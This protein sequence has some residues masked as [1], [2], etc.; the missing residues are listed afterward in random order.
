MIFKLRIL[1]LCIVSGVAFLAGC[2]RAEV[3]PVLSGVDSNAACDPATTDH[4]GAAS[5]PARGMFH[6]AVGTPGHII[7]GDTLDVEIGGERFKVRLQ[8]VSAPECDKDTTEPYGR[9]SCVSDDEH[10]GVGS[11][12]LIAE[13]LDGRD[14]R[15]TC[16]D[17]APGEECPADDYDRY[18]VYLNAECLGDVGEALIER[19]GALSFTRYPTD[20]RDAYC[21][22]EDRARAASRG[23]WQLGDRST[24]LAAMNGNT[25]SWYRDR[26]ARCDAAR[27]D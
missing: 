19:G 2:E 12:D 25:R 13:L 6:G 11:R 14:V 8:G 27:Q 4:F 26:D 21:R 10:F 1:H 23:L 18:L 20:K 17:A 7:D 9:Y 3:E 24:V 5:D 15:V 22:A 16:Q